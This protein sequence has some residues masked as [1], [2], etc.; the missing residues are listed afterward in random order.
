VHFQDTAEKPRKASFSGQRDDIWAP[1]AGVFRRWTYVIDI[2]AA[3]QV[4][5]NVINSFRR[6]Y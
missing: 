6:A 3:L 4:A 2:T 1:F 5:L